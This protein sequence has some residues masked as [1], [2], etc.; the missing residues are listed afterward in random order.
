MDAPKCDRCPAAP[1]ETWL[2]SEVGSDGLE[3][4]ARIL[5]LCRHHSREHQLPLYDQGFR[6]VEVAPV[7][8]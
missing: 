5:T 2:H 3:P 4:S 7:P 1:A 8:A 6:L